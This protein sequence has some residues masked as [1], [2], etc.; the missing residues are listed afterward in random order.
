MSVYYLL[1]LLLALIYVFNRGNSYADFNDL[2]YHICTTSKRKRGIILSAFILLLIM[3]LRA[4]TVGTDTA[5]YAREYM[6]LA[7]YKFTD[8]EFSFTGEV[9][10]RLL[11]WVFLKLGFSWQMFLFISS[12]FVLYST[13]CFINRYSAN[14][15]L[16]FYLYVTVG[17]F[18]MNMTGLRQSLAV[19]ILLFAFEFG[20]RKKFLKFI[21][22]CFLAGMI[23]YA[24]F[25]FIPVWLIFYY[26]YRSKRQLFIVLLFPIV[27][28]VLATP[29]YNLITKFALRKYY[30]S[31][32]FDS[33][34][35]K[36]NILVELVAFTT[37]LVCYIC[38]I[39]SKK[40]IK[41]REFHFFILT[42][43]YVTCIELS[44][45]VY[46]AGR[47]NFFF[48][49]FMTTLLGNIAYRLENRKI[50]YLA[51]MTIMVVS[52]LQFMISIPGASYGIDSY[53]FFWNVR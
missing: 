52:L 15:F 4:T 20:R 40:E 21:I 22:C 9:G 26:P 27:V 35:Y 2:E 24:G 19:A 25:V 31:G 1:M 38:L 8:F 16:G 30:F 34:N 53:K 13:A 28:R 43:I 49:F 44:H 39:I 47:L 46:M 6:Q 3:G 48:I 29:I 45:V 41:E 33:L 23:H 17:M 51:I 42:S 10:F 37:L 18:A 32:Y 7:T 36:L 50:R 5:S 14:Y 11:Q 12:M